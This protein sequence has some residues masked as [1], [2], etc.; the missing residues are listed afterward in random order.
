LSIFYDLFQVRLNGI[1]IFKCF[2]IFEIFLKK[3]L[4]AETQG[5]AGHLVDFNE[6]SFQIGKVY[7][8]AAV[9]KKRGKPRF[10][11]PAVSF[12]MFKCKK[13]SADHDHRNSHDG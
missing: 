1:E 3:L 8:I 5:F 13:Y 9:M 6:V 10:Q 2:E 4:P 12:G 11:F 7:F